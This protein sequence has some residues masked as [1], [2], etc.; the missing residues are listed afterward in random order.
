MSLFFL[1]LGVAT[2]DVNPAMHLIKIPIT[3]GI[4]NI[5]CEQAF[6]NK[7]VWKENPNYKEGNG[8]VWG[9]YTYK[10][11]PVFLHYCKDKKGN[12]VR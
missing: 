2:A 11:K 5:T 6:K 9:Y 4:K 3:Q 7:T 8:E 10:D 1:I 12:W